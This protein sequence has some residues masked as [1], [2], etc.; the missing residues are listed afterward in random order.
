MTRFEPVWTVPFYI[1]GTRYWKDIERIPVKELTK[2][3]ESNSNSFLAIYNKGEIYTHETQYHHHFATQLDGPLI[4]IFYLFIFLKNID[5]I[6]LLARDYSS[7]AFGGLGGLACRS[8]APWNWHRDTKT[9]IGPAVTPET[10]TISDLE[11]WKQWNRLTLRCLK[12]EG[13]SRR[14][15]CGQES[16]KASSLLVWLSVGILTG[17]FVYLIYVE[18]IIRAITWHPSSRLRGFLA[19][20]RLVPSRCRRFG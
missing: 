11:P 20:S 9:S 14:A 19:D 10:Y 5:D 2:V 4:M 15:S 13:F 18:F 12:S 7:G 1:T 16:L 17:A 3:C 8:R 6:F